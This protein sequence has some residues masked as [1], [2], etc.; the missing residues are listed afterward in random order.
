MTENNYNPDDDEETQNDCEAQAA[1]AKRQGTELIRAHLQSHL[2]QNPSSS[3]VT[4]IAT[5]HPE[6][7]HVTIDQRFLIPGNPWLTV[8]QETIQAASFVANRS[9][10]SATPEGEGGTDR[11]ITQAKQQQ[12]E[13]EDQV[14]TK[15]HQGGFV[16]LTLGIAMAVAAGGTTLGFEAAILGLHCISVGCQHVAAQCSLRGGA[17]P[18]NKIIKV[19]PYSLFGLVGLVTQWTEFLLLVTSTGVVELL[20]M[21]SGLLCG[22]LGGC[23]LPVGYAAHQLTRRLS[24]YIRWACRAQWWWWHQPTPPQQQTMSGGASVSLVDAN[25]TIM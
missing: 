11:H 19:V 5:L 14:L 3:Y 12:Q 22:L 23:S 16:V 25:G 17:S 18:I 1:A 9:S 6:N 4:W 15:I 13:K 8:Y 21:I 20:A 2:V 24:H 10:S 7:A